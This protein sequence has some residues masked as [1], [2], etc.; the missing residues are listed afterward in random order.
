MILKNFLGESTACRESFTNIF[1]YQV[2]LVFCKIPMLLSLIKP[3]LWYPLSVKI[4]GFIS[5]LRQR[6]LWDLIL[7]VVTEPLSCIVIKQLIFFLDLDGLFLDY[8]RIFR[9]F[10]TYILF[11][12]QR[13]NLDLSGF[14]DGAFPSSDKSMLGQWL[15][16]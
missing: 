15:F 7:L 9:I 12:H 11:N 13:Q 16:P 4:T 8:F 6:Y 1:S 5:L 3:I 2:I 14:W 10:V